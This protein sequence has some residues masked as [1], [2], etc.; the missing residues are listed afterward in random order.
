[1][2]DKADGARPEIFISHASS[3]YRAA[4]LLAEL[5]LAMGAGAVDV[6]C[7]SSPGFDIP[8]GTGFFQHI[9]QLLGRSA[10]VVHFITPAF[11]R[12]EFCM[13]EVGAAW[14]QGKS[15]PILAP[16][17]KIGDMQASPLA[18]L[19]LT[20]VMPADGLDRLRDRIGDI[21]HLPA[22]TAGWS[23]RRDRAVQAISQVLGETA[24]TRI[25]RLAA[26]GIKDHRIEAWAVRTDGR[27]SHAWLPLR[28]GAKRWTEPRDF[29]VPGGIVDLAAAS[30][31][32]GHAE[33]FAL[34]NRGVLWHRW[35]YPEQWSGW[36]EFHSRR[37]APPIAA[38]SYRDGH[39]EVFALDAASNTVI[40]RW[41]NNAPRW[42]DDWIPLDEGLEPK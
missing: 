12:S 33:V 20:T 2:D 1:M 22:K 42:K 3:D 41:S 37:V 38:C 6:F 15:F 24:Q 25:S 17:L 13:L 26:L 8:V 27:V 18:S 14:A 5:V 39:I 40:H 32:S 19:Q 28:D 10:L 34:D 21:I 31:G 35:W 30:R 4:V 29:P 23:D 36:H 9:Q 16:P 7:T 11:L